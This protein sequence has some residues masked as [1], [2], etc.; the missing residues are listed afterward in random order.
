MVPRRLRAG[1]TTNPARL[2]ALL[3]LVAITIGTAVLMLP[4]SSQADGSA[5][6]LTALFTATSAV[7][8]TG[9]IVVDTP[10]YWSTFGQTALLVMFQVGGFGILTGTSLAFLALT[11]RIGFRGRLLAEAEQQESD[12]SQLKRVL[13]TAIVVTVAFELLAWLSIS[14]DLIRSGYGSGAAAWEGL[15]HSVSAFN[16]AGFALYPDSLERFATD[17]WMLVTIAIATIVGGLGV[18]VW[19]DVRRAGLRW[20]RYNLHTK[21]TL[22]GTA[23]LLAAGFIA[24]TS[25]EWDNEHTIGGLGIPGRLLG[26][27]FASVTPRSLGFS[28]F[29][30]GQAEVETL[31]V[32]DA[33]MFVGGGSASTAGG[34]KVGTFV[35]LM[36]VVWGEMRGRVEVDA[37]GRTVP[38]PILR[39]AFS[40]AFLALV[41][42]ALGTLA[43]TVSSG[44]SLEESLFEA[45]SAFA[46]VGLSTGITPG[47]APAGQIAVIVLMYAGRVG[48]VTVALAL[49]FRERERRYTFP[50]E[51]PL[52][53]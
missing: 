38:S 40:L 47:L 27:F 46:T 13:S 52:V 17:G 14:L 12:A 53:G 48:L 22:S 41:A 20:S 25:F 44:F 23:A 28:T 24:F 43:I 30:Y 37:F 29:D 6:F 16:G 26:G 11:R 19:L 36:L 7:C 10:T 21:L 34:I 9:L 2:L 49:A 42:I 50:E 5:S 18:P 3:F 4:A 35:L 31:L 1:I 33:F 51:R 39:R 32:S 15:F 45:V 8:V